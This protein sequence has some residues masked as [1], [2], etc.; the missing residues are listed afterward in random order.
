M[1]ASL[2][3][4][5]HDAGGAGLCPRALWRRRHVAAAHRRQGAPRHS[6]V[7]CKYSPHPLLA[8]HFL[9][10]YW[11]RHCAR[12][13]SIEVV[14]SFL[15][16]QCQSFDRYFPKCTVDAVFSNKRAGRNDA[17]GSVHSIQSAVIVFLHIY[18]S[19]TIIKGSH[20][21]C[22]VGLQRAIYKKLAVICAP[23]HCR[24]KCAANAASRSATFRALTKAPS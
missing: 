12:V 17:N 23:Q 21:K 9:G 3:Y 1:P 18:G 6:L 19:T 11:V 24:N 16:C 13:G 8:P 20:I 2:Y 22:T 5:V 10:R 15:T 7:A 4:G 14:R